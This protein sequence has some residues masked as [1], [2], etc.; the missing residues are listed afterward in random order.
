MKFFYLCSA[1]RK[2]KFIVKVRTYFCKPLNTKVTSNGELCG[3]CFRQVKKL[4]V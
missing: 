3:K 4:V 1:C 2:V